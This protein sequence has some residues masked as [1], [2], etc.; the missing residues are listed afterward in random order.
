MDRQGP[1]IAPKNRERI[2]AEDRRKA[3]ELLA[4]R[5]IFGGGSLIR[6]TLASSSAGIASSMGFRLGLGATEGGRV[7]RGRYAEVQAHLRP[8]PPTP[9]PRRARENDLISYLI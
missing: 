9:S 5:P 8:P 2:S 1:Q 7:L 4:T 6:C 3:I